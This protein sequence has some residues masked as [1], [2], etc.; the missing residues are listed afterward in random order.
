VRPTVV[1][2]GADPKR[3]RHSTSDSWP[4][5]VADLAIYR[6]EVACCRRLSEVVAVTLVVSAR[7]LPSLRWA[8]LN[9]RQDSWSRV[10]KGSRSDAHSA[11]LTT[12][13]RGFRI[14]R[15]EG[16]PFLQHAAAGDP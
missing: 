12:I 13:L 6:S 7:T 9:P 3:S 5:T 4:F 16:W 14:G 1:V 10:P 2:L 11:P 8:P 15:P